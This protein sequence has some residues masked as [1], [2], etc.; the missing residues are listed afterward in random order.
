MKNFNCPIGNR[1]RQFPGRSAVIHQTVPPCIRPRIVSIVNCRPTAQVLSN[2]RK[3]MSGPVAYR[4][5]GV[6]TPVT[7]NSEV[8]TKLSQIPSSVENTSVTT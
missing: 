3:H 2:K 4:E 7:R 8:L 6:Q 1:N 5:G